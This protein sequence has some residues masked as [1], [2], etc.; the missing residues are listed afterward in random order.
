ML[1]F[2]YIA[3]DSKRSKKKGFI[4]ADSKNSAITL[5]MQQGLIP[6]SVV[7][8]QREAG[9]KNESIFTRDISFVSLNKKKVSKKRL[10]AFANQ[11]SIMIRAGVPLTT[12]MDVLTF[13]ESDKTFRK[14]LESIRNDLQLGVHLSAAM[15]KFRAFPDI[16]VNMV[17][18]GEAD[19]RL[20]IAF[21][22]ISTSLSRDLLLTSRIR[23]AS[24]YPVFLLVLTLAIVVII[25]IFVLPNFVAI[26]EN[27]D[28]QLPGITRF[29]MG[30]AFFITNKWYI[31]LGVAAALV[32]L[33]QLL[34][35]FSEK[36]GFVT[37]KFALNLPVIGRL[38]KRIYAARFCEVLSS[39]TLAGIDIYEGFKI[40][41]N[42][43]KNSYVKKKL[44][45]IMDDIQIGA[46]ISNAME[47]NNPFDRLLLSMVHTGEESGMLPETLGKMAELYEDQVSESIKLIN[48]LLEPIMTVII[49]VIVGVVI[50]SMVL[51]M[52]GIYRLL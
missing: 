7:D 1:T 36:F 4:E 29:M 21:Q 45:Q 48:S 47:K 28:T 52:F 42:T 32:I 22:R 20:D 17:E 46:T 3:E 25:S 27:F 31:P 24:V 18:A 2:R 33:Y 35:R 38:K 50:I 10:V 15:R 13:E 6:I 51:P 8:T 9:E 5:L 14:I 40:T 30:F 16:F 43:I 49:A 12:V 23:S 44:M 41:T 39:I 26:F 34:R 11:M 37:G 19:G